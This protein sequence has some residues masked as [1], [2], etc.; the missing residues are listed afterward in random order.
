MLQI[1]QR[2]IRS[3]SNLVSRFKNV[4]EKYGGKGIIFIKSSN[5]ELF[6]SYKDLY[7]KSLEFAYLAKASGLKRG[8]KLI[9]QFNDNEKFLI[10][11]WGSIIGGEAAEKVL[12]IAI[13]N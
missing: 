5:E 1:Y 3:L 8:D 9:L 13:S 7:K 2:G 12:D 10:S 6:L 4:V 11:F